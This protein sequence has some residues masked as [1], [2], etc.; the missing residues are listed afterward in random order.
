LALIQA[1]TVTAVEASTAGENGIATESLTPSKRADLSVSLDTRPVWPSSVP[2][3][4]VP[5]VVPAASAAV[6]PDV[7]PRR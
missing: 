4:Y 6:V 2:L 5:G 3:R 7:S 1:S